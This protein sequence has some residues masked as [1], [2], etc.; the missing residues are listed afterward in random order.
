MKKTDVLPYALIF[1]FLLIKVS[2]FRVLIFDAKSILHIVLIEF[3]MWAFLL[4]VILLLAKK[5]LWWTVW[6]FNLLT[7]VIFFVVTLYIRYYSTIP[8][9]YDLQQLTQSSSVGG[10]ITMLSTPWDFLFSLTLCY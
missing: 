10:T 4:S 6:I 9:Y 2:V 1:L 8:S 7:S 3:P 5:Q